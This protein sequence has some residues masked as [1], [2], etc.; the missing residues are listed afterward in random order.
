MDISPSLVRYNDFWYKLKGQKIIGDVSEKNM[1]IEICL[2]IPSFLTSLSL[3]A[4][5]EKKKIFKTNNILKMKVTHC[6]SS[7]KRVKISL[8][9]LWFRN[10]ILV[11]LF[12][13]GGMESVM[14]RR[15]KEKDYSGSYVVKWRR[16]MNIQLLH[17]CCC[18]WSNPIPKQFLQKSVCCISRSEPD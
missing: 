15:N 7:K 18:S 8:D 3:L 1:P 16:T 10:E 14:L 5:R 6:P 17:S 2:I 11:Y 4:K 9:C 12:I 13:L